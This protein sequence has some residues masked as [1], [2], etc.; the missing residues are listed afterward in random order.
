MKLRCLCHAAALAAVLLAGGAHASLEAY[1]SAPDDS[2]RFD[3]VEE[4]ELE[5]ARAYVVKMTSQTWRGIPWWHWMTVIVPTTLTNPE[6]A[7]LLIDGGNNRDPERVPGMGTETQVLARVATQTGTVAARVGQVPN[8]PLMGDRYE[9]ALIAYTYDQYLKSGETDWPLLFPMVKSATAAMT[10]VQRLV[11]TRRGAAV[12][13][14]MLTGGSKRGWTSW[15]AAAAD[16]RVKAI[17]PFVID[18]LNMAPQSEHQLKSYGG[19]SEMVADYTE[20]RL[21]ERTPTPEGQV[22]LKWVDPYFYR[23]RL[24]LPKMI[25][26]GANDPYWT[27]DAA[28]LY[29]DDLVGEKHLYYQANTGHDTSLQGIATLTHF[30]QAV[31]KG[32]AFPKVAWEQSDL[33]RIAVSWD[34]PD[35]K[36][37]LWTATSP[38][39]DFRSSTWSSQ[40][41]EGAGAATA[42]VA[43]PESGWLAYYVE[44]RFP[45]E[46][47][48]DFGSTTKMTVIPDTFP[49][50]GRTYDT[51]EAKAAASEREE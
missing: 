25:V 39:R 20:Y 27:V 19:H 23:D 11:E 24:T 22:L 44:V 30:Y 43:T 7:L 37:L 9:D 41:L 49:T 10:T 47:G 13:G 8:Q 14:F 46:L 17:A 36:A 2:Y 51:P 12:S 45:G 50:E 18:T 28:N 34:R 26:L 3:V 31:V 16:P 42:E 40:P 15:L 48:M 32:S 5:G 4:R 38:N 29:F 6:T 21:Q 1:V 35:G 33:N